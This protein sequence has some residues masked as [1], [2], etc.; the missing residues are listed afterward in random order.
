MGVLV[1]KIAIQLKFYFQFEVYLH[2]LWQFCVCYLIILFGFLLIQSISMM[3]IIFDISLNYDYRIKYKIKVE[4]L[5]IDLL[6]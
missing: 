2:N 3:F 5:E 6:Y 4:F 1:E